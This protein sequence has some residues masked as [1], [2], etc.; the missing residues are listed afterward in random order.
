L[1]APRVATPLPPLLE[2]LQFRR[3]PTTLLRSRSLR[4]RLG[5]AASARLK[6]LWFA[7]SL[8]AAR[9]PA[10]RLARLFCRSISKQDLKRGSEAFGSLPLSFLLRIL[11]WLKLPHRDTFCQIRPRKR[12][13][14]GLLLW[15]GT[16]CQ[17]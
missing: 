8:R 17:G 13:G 10:K 11:G 3:R 7:C 14:C 6:T 16:Q 9:S 15:A 5:S 12:A 2:P 4:T 1:P